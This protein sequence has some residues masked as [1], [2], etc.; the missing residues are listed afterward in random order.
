MNSLTGSRPHS[1]FHSIIKI[2]DNA[3][4]LTYNCG[5]FHL[6]IHP[7]I[8]EKELICAKGPA[9]P[10]TRDLS[11]LIERTTAENTTFVNVIETCRK[12]DE[13]ID[14]VDF[15]SNENCIEITITFKDSTKKMYKI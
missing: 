7:M 14:H 6:H 3:K 1:H 9:N 8:K 13:C 5:E 4:K 2:N 11:Y 10:A 15:I 12:E